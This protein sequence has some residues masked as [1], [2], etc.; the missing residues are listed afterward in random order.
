MP[1]APNKP[2]PVMR[3]RRIV[4]CSCG[5]AI[6]RRELYQPL[7]PTPCVDCGGI[8]REFAKI[9]NGLIRHLIGALRLWLWKR[10]QRR[11]S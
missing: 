9:R 4:V 7:K 6:P 5:R 1:L 3:Y 11:N 10:H 8:T 2:L